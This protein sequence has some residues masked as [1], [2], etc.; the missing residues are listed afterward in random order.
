MPGVTKQQIAKAKEWDLLSYLMVHE[1]EE[2]KKSGPEEYRTKTHDSLVI[3]NG[4]WHWF[5]RNIGGRSALDYLIKV[6]GEDF[7]TAVNHL[8]HGTPSPSLFQPVEKKKSG[9]K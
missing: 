7:I 8:Y 6:R 1:P 4:K 5:S 2:L 9:K 3:S